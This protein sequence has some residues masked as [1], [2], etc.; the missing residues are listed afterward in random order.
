MQYLIPYVVASEIVDRYD[1]W[2]NTINK[3][4]IVF[5]KILAKKYPKINLVWQPDGVM[6][7][8]QLMLSIKIV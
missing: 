3:Q 4:D 2:L 8:N 1:L 5:F 7:I 6:V